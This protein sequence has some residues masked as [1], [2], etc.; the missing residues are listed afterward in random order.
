MRNF[1]TRLLKPI[2][3]HY[4]RKTTPVSEV[5]GMD[6][7]QPVDRYYIEKFLSEN[8]QYIKG[9]VLEISDN[10]YT[11]LFGKGVTQSHILHYTNDNPK[12]TIIGDLADLNSLPEA[13]VD[14]FICTQTF[15]FI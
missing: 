15:N 8:Q 1:I 6:R 5:F 13:A 14:C 12:A 4:L 11:T 3:W 2:R 9:Q 7:G 10:T